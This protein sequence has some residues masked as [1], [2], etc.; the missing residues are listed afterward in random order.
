MCG[1]NMK[2]KKITC[3]AAPRE[4]TSSGFTVTLGSLSV[5]F[6]TSSCTAGIRVDPPTRITSSRSLTDNLA[7]LKA[8]FTGV[9]SLSPERMSVKPSNKN[10]NKHEILQNDFKALDSKYWQNVHSYLSIRSEHSSS[11]LALERVASMCFGPSA[12]AVMN[13]KLHL[14][15]FRNKKFQMM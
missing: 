7:S 4:T 10:E 8:L 13:G 5:S 2:G 1:R 15:H 3:T 6:L 14:R 12:V 11:N 9:L